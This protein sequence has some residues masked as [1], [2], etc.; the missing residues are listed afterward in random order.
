MYVYIC[1][2]TNVYIYTNRYVCMHKG[3]HCV[4]PHVHGMAIVSMFTYKSLLYM[5]TYIYIYIYPCAFSRVAIFCT[6]AGTGQLLSAARIYI[7]TSF[8]YIYIYIYI[9]QNVYVYVC[10]YKNSCTVC[11]HG[12]RMG[13]VGSPHVYI[14]L[15]YVYMYKYIRLRLY[16]Q[17]M[18]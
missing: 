18:Q 17:E 7:H 11:P 16:V 4:C 12:H 14:I 13:I 10:M 3:C 8:L 9:Y 5:Y 6:L 15:I 2:C 1:I